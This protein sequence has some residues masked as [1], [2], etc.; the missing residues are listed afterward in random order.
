MPIGG[1]DAENRITV[2]LSNNKETGSAFDTT[3][4]PTTV[5]A[6]AHQLSKT[7]VD[8]S[9]FSSTKVL[10]K[11]NPGRFLKKGSGT[12]GLS[13][14]DATA[15]QVV[16]VDPDEERRK[17]MS[18][19][20]LKVPSAKSARPNPANTEYRRFYER[21]DLPIQM[22]HRGVTNGLMWK[23][24]IQKLDYHHYLPIFVDGLRETEHP[25]ECMAE[26]GVIDM[27]QKGVVANGNNKVL[28]VIPQLIIPIKTALN[29][30]DPRVIV[31]VIK[32]LMLLVDVGNIGIDASGNGLQDNL[33]GQALVPYY[34]QILPI[35]NIF[36]SGTATI[37]DAID[38][39]QQKNTNLPELC[40]Q[41]LEEFER[42]G[43]SDA[44]INIKYLVPTYQS[45]NS[46]M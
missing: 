17:K 1:N 42:T 9:A 4:A 33:I 28:P 37:G 46:A 5:R 35:I 40:M 25:Y 13:G 8:A 11:P 23:V 41:C 10:V 14:K 7:D 45:I 39:G 38:Y 21:G 16:D 43:G 18:N 3:M 31:K 2:K 26:Q 30:R 20:K 22:D 19:R 24:D 36:V 27:L 34:R 44:F 32:I 6:G 29:T 15:K 12:G